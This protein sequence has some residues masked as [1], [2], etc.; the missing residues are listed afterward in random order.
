MSHHLKA[1][2]AILLAE[3][4]KEVVDLRLHRRPVVTLK[5]EQLR[6]QLLGIPRV[7]HDEP[8]DCLAT[9][10]E[11]GPLDLVVLGLHLLF[12]GLDDQQRNRAGK[13]VVA[14]NGVSHCHVADDGLG[15]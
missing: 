2:G 10:H 6:R 9:Q 8:R 13:H 4:S 7:L 5:D 15:E 11:E 3:V 14:R 1:C 12:G